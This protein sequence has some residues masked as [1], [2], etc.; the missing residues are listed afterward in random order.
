MP[1]VQ[2][3]GLK[4]TY[5]LVQTYYAALA[6]FDQHL[7]TRETAVRQPFLDLLRRG[8][9]PARLVTLTRIS[10]ARH[11]TARIPTSYL[12]PVPHVRH[13][14]AGLGNQ[15]ASNPLSVGIIMR[16]TFCLFASD[17]RGEV[18]MKSLCST[19]NRKHVAKMKECVQEQGRD[20]RRTA[21]GRNVREVVVLSVDEKEDGSG[22]FSRA[23]TD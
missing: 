6:Q 4:P 8:R 10:Y 20:L 16:Y 13:N 14:G 18:Q 15:T 11:P 21:Q 1:R 5:K 3:P 9:R 23:E 7:V 17:S 2:Q 12:F 19:T 22:A